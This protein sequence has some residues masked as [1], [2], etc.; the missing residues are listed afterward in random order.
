LPALPFRNAAGPTSHGR[1]GFIAKLSDHHRRAAVL[2]ADALITFLHAAY[3]EAEPNILRTHEPY[4]RLEDMN[5]LID[6]QAYLQALA[7]C[8]EA[9][10]VAE[11]VISEDE[12]A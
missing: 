9:A 6:R 8:R 5:A 12:A 1:D 2:S 11:E 10:A 4:E 7:A 3:L